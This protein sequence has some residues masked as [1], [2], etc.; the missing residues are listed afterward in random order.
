MLFF[1]KK[2]SISLRLLRAR[3]GFVGPY[4]LRWWLVWR[5]MSGKC[6]WL[7]FPRAGPILWMLESLFPEVI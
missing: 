5:G 3:Q 2:K 4:L 7:D 6:E 1:K